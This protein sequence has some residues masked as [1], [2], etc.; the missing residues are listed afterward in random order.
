[1]RKRRSQSAVDLALRRRGGLNRADGNRRIGQTIAARRR[2]S[3]D[4]YRG[5]NA[6][7]FGLRAGDSGP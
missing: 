5:R 2:V 7:P 3:D 6:A 4:G 1:M